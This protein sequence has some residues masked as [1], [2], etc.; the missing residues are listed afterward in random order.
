MSP[1]LQ[2]DY[3]N[4]NYARLKCAPYEWSYSP[5]I[6]TCSRLLRHRETSY[7]AYYLLTN[8]LGL[9]T[10]NARCWH[11][12]RHRHH[13]HHH[14]HHYNPLGVMPLQLLNMWVRSLWWRVFAN[15]GRKHT[16]TR[17][18]MDRRQTDLLKLQSWK[19]NVTKI[20]TNGSKN[21]NR[22]TQSYVYIILITQLNKFDPS[23]V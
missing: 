14:H 23:S 18:R 3:L 10:R 17:N 20:T 7:R 8:G 4:L 15:E 12:Y 13:H 6:Q 22:G 5:M 11:Y 1:Y 21:S 16:V 2:F 9:G 19:D